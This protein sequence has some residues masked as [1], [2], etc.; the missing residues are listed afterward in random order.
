MFV[1]YFAKD[2]V[3]H[4]HSDPL[5]VTCRGTHFYIH[6]SFIRLDKECE[7]QLLCQYT[8][9]VLDA[10]GYSEQLLL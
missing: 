6:G 9:S 7:Y 2:Y 4:V 3:D 10:D 5:T 1:I 8:C